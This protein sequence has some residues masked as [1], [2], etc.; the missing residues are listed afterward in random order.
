[1]SLRS[2]WARLSAVCSLVCL[3]ASGSVLAQSGTS[4]LRGTVTDEQGSAVPGATLTLSNASMG[5]KRVVTTDGSGD[6][7][8][9]A[10]PPGSHKLTVELSGFRT[11]VFENVPLSVDTI[12]RQDVRVVVGAVAE[13]VE[14]TASTT[15]INTTDASLGN[16]ITGNQVR[17]LPL[18]GRN[19][20][21]L[22]SLQAGAVYLP[23][24]SPWRG[25]AGSRPPTA[26]GRAVRRLPSPPG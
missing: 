3:L 1:M 12:A 19:V 16:V 21:G 24:P 5:F 18:E 23:R 13:T 17:A 10:V 6:Y 25:S 9:V 26:S 14:V 11:S 7:Q 22:L 8:F 2:A 15:V 20:V 4:G